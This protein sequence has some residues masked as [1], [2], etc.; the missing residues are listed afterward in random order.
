ML[1][2]RWVTRRGARILS[3]DFGRNLRIIERKKAAPLGRGRCSHQKPGSTSGL[4]PEYLLIGFP[5]QGRLI[6]F[7]DQRRWAAALAASPW[8]HNILLR[9]GDHGFQPATFGLH[10]WLLAFCTALGRSGLVQTIPHLCGAGLAGNMATDNFRMVN[11]A[12]VP[13][14]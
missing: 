4:R 12:K 1:P 14:G 13:R 7:F 11:P 8:H 3:A 2:E 6:V 9:C 10:G 5:D